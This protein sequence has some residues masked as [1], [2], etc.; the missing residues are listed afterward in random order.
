MIPIVTAI[1][2]SVAPKLAQHGLDLLS[3]IFS[4]ATETGIE[5][6]K[7]LIEDKTGIELKDIAGD[8]MT[9]DDWDRLQTFEKENRA[10][11]TYYMHMDDNEVKREQTHQRDRA[12]ARQL[13]QAAIASSD[14][15]AQRFIYFYASAITLLTFAF[16]FYASFFHDF[17][18]NPGSERIIDTIVGFLLGIALSAIVQFFF[19]SSVGSRSKDYQI[20]TLSENN[21][22]R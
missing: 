9:Q 11:L 20:S 8:A 22:Q 12:S 18:A 16:I 4:G 5:K 21:G 17:E 19:G 3:E 7:D 14:R 13:Q 6:V 2:A 15:L 1:L 10:K